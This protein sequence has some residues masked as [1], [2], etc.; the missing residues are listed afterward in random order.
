MSGR[1]G[2]GQR[3]INDTGGKL[4]KF[5]FSK[6]KQNRLTI[7][8]LIGANTRIEGN[9]FFSAGLRIDG[10]VKGNVVG[11]PNE[12][13]MLV[14]SEKAKIDGSVVGAHVVVNGTINGPVS[15]TELLELQPNARIYG[16]VQY[17]AL[18][19][20]PGAVI[21]GTLSHRTDVNPA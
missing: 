9:L 3:G 5:M 20:H 19:M 16:D 6:Q 14:L 11:A 21:S 4:E 10:Q 18:E 8:S 7:D 13:T 15:A 2:E 12:K 17:V 1:A